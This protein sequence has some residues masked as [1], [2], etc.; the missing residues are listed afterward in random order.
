MVLRLAEALEVPLRDRNA[1]LA[2]AGHPPAFADH[3]L[4]D[5]QLRPFR[6]AIDAILE[7]HS[8]YPGCALDLF[9]EVK[10]A[11]D[12]CRALWPGLDQRSA[13]EGVDTFYGHTHRQLIDNW[14]DVAWGGLDRLRHDARRTQH[15]RMLALLERAEKH[16]LGVQRSGHTPAS[17]PILCPRFRVGEQ[18]I[19]TFSTVM[20]F[21]TSQ[22]ITLGELKVEL[23]FP[24]DDVGDAFFRKLASSR[25]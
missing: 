1:L 19:E 6:R 21:E 5:D 24:A 13:E 20:R 18:L 12:A 25:P 15:P 23:I 10:I 2:A 7:R 4:D 14:A 8:P 3:A 9:G 22:D 16:M 17:S 11:N